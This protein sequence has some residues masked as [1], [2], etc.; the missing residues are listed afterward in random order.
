L[1]DFDAVQGMFTN[2]RPADALQIWD[3]RGRGVRSKIK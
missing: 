3:H 1:A 2:E